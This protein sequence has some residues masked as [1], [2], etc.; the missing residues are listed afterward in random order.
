MLIQENNIYSFYTDLSSINF[1]TGIILNSYIWFHLFLQQHYELLL[2][3]ISDNYSS[4]PVTM[5]A[6]EDMESQRS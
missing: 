3:Y 1:K 2:S 6:D 4:I 5:F